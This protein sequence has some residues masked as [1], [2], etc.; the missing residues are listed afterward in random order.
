MKLK[1]TFAFAVL[2]I[3]SCTPAYLTT[4]PGSELPNAAF[5]VCLRNDQLGRCEKWKFGNGQIR[6]YDIP[7]GYKLVPERSNEEKPSGASSEKP[8]SEL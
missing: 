8:K 1:I 6:P 5:D 3:G 4:S 7:P 2:G